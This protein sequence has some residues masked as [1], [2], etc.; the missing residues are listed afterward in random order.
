MKKIAVFTFDMQLSPSCLC[1]MSKSTESILGEADCPKVKKH[2]IKL[3]KKICNNNLVFERK[4]K[5]GIINIY[6]LGDKKKLMGIK[7]GLIRS[8]K[9]YCK[10]I[11]LK[12]EKKYVPDSAWDKCHQAKSPIDFINEYPT[13]KSA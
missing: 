10:D 7:N 9:P 8:F 3:L 5:N 11:R 6:L 12:I 13:R 2:N 1:L 4:D